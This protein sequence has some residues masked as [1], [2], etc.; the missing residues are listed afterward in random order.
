MAPAAAST[1]IRSPRNLQPQT[2]SSSPSHLPVPLERLRASPSNSGTLS[3]SSSSWSPS[4]STIN[5]SPPQTELDSQS[6]TH[7]TPP[8]TPS[9]SVLSHTTSPS[10]LP[11]S[12]PSD[13]PASGDTSNGPSF[14][15]AATEDS[16][17]S[18]PPERDVWRQQL[19]KWLHI[20]TW[21]QGSIAVFTLAIGVVGLVYSAYRTYELALWTA[22]KEWHEKCQAEKV[23]SRMTLTL[24]LPD[25][26]YCR[27][28]IT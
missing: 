26:L 4:S 24:R 20:R 27:L 9:Q 12:A 7:H 16:S 17:A 21:W 1:I 15:G 13:P 18:T 10:L 6:E 14:R 25:L 3:T 23:P 11:W 5:V 8:T 28:P 19:R 22:A 2:N